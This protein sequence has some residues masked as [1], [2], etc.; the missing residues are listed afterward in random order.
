MKLIIFAVFFGVLIV[1]VNAYISPDGLASCNDSPS[2]TQ[3]CQTADM[4]V[5]VS[6]GDTSARVKE[7]IALYKNGWAPRILFS[8]AAEDKTGPSNAQ[9]MAQMAVDQGVPTNSVLME[10]MSETT[11]QNAKNAQA[12]F[13]Q[14]AVRS[15]IV[16]SSPYHMRRTA[17]EFTQAS[18]DVSIRAHP[19]SNDSGWSMW[20]WLTPSGWYLVASE[21][22]KIV[23]LST[24]GVNR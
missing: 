13:T 21:M 24:G 4:I 15:A 23:I 14:Y 7:A 2:S 22:V 20:W 17:L 3:P 10:T 5:V 8:G 12:I 11:Q 19:A 1:G 16:V 9:V 6:G 18:T